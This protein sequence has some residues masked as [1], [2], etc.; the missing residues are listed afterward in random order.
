M[1][2]SE[3]LY[4]DNHLIAINKPAGYLVQGDETGDETLVEI[5][6]RYVK[7]E[8]RKPGNVFLGPNHRLDRPVSGVLLFSKTSKALSR[9]NKMFQDR[10]VQKKYYAI[11]EGVPDP[12]Q[13]TL[14]HYI[15]KNRKKNISF[16]TK[17]GSF[18]SKKSVLAYKVEKIINNK[19]LLEIEPITGRSHQIRVQLASLKTPILGD[20]KY[21]ATAKMP[22]R[23]IALHCKSIVFTH[24]VKK[25]E[26]VI[27]AAVPEL[28]V[29]KNFFE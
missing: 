18:Q 21:G 1:N 17:K 12:M 26:V 6:K 13:G 16:I 22:D 20:L 9:T 15:A 19:C 10:K 14:T 23:S 3:I 27:E 2:T 5:V 8:Y 24:P 7:Q 28:P 11:V 29:W 4:E 25:E